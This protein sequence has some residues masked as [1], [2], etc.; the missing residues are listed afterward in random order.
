MKKNIAISL[1]PNTQKDDVLL[2][3]KELFTPISW[4]DF[5]KTERLERKFEEY[6]GRGFKALAVNSGRGAEYLILK[7]SGIG[8]G[9]EVAIQAFTCVTVPNSIIWLG[10]KPSYVDIDNSFNI[11]PKALSEK[12]SEKTRAIIV[13]HSFGI[14]AKIE[15]I[16]KIARKKKLLLIEDCAVS[17]GGSYKNKRLGTFGDVAFFSFGRDKVI[18]SVFGG[19]IVTKDKRFYEKIKKER[20]SLNYPQPFWLVQQLLH[21]ILFNLFILPTF[22]LGV[23]KSTLGKLFLYIF[24]KL[25]ILSRAVYQEEKMGRKPYYFPQKMPGALASLALKQFEKLD[26]FNSQRREIAS[27]YRE[28]F[29]K[30]KFK[31]PPRVKGAIWL[32][33]PLLQ[34][35]LSLAKKKNIQLGDWYRKVIYPVSDTRLVGYRKGLCP[36]AERASEKIINLPTYP[37][38]SKKEAGFIVNLIRN[39]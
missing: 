25:K 7:A 37:N 5:R 6:F 31:I 35:I 38:I 39:G 34:T 1:S 16:K 9:S 2:A 24:L 27:F 22:G 13:Q 28:S 21:P 30:S 33:F 14:P 18:S 15:L 12:L 10:A 11:D 8:K 36:N 19:M 29:S 3:F 17:L 32:R 26:K 4:F 20:D 23:G